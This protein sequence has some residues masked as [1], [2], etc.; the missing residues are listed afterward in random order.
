MDQR[1]I[2][3][4]WIG[5]SLSTIERLAISSFL[6]NGHQFHL[7]TYGKVNN[8]PEG[9]V[10]MDAREICELDDS[11]QVKEGFGKGSY[12][13]FAD[14]FRFQMLAKKGGWW[15]DLDVVCLQ[16]FQGL[17]DTVVA[18]SLEIPE[19]DLPNCNV[20]SFPAGHWFP[21]QCLER[22]KDS[23]H[24]KFHYA[25]GVEVV[26]SIVAENN[27]E[28]F[29]VSHHIFNPISWRHVRYLVDKPEP[30]WQPISLKRLLGL[31]EPIGKISSDSRA[32]H[33]WNEGWRQ[34]GFDKNATY[35]SDSIF[36]SLKRR[37][38]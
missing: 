22:W 21:N 3:S 37:Y 35:P 4:L 15:V 18:T 34:G 1:P 23:F 29:L 25:L 16:S 2:Q 10:I 12:A 19:G 6:K 32:I 28:G 31:A 9:T 7:Y 5:D 8:V 26:K 27:A 17:P 11:I 13:P 24:E 36:E 30:I 14:Y 38:L 20:L 33:L